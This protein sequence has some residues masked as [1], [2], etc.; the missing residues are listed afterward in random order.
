MNR[1]SIY[2]I[3]NIETLKHSYMPWSNRLANILSSHELSEVEKNRMF[4]DSFISLEK[5]TEQ[6]KNELID[7]KRRYGEIEQ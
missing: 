4:V 1:L 7:Y 2:D 6:Y 3:E 5:V